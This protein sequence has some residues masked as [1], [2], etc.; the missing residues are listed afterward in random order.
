MKSDASVPHLDPPTPFVRDLFKPRI[1]SLGSSRA[2]NPWLLKDPV[3][4]GAVQSM[5][6]QS[7]PSSSLASSSLIITSQAPAH[8]VQCTPPV[9][10]FSILS[11]LPKSS[12]HPKVT[13]RKPGVKH[14]K[15]YRANRCDALG[16]DTERS[17]EQRGGIS[18]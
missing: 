12:S 17:F 11:F 18:V 9:S 5:W 16:K 4:M 14:R 13:I 8:A 15:R 2:R 1:N 7:R 10:M 6:L 3:V